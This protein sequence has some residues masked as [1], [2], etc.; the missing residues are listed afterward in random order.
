MPGVL[1]LEEG[2]WLQFDSKGRCNNGSIN[3]LTS[4]EACSDLSQSTSSNTCLVYAKKCTDAE[5]MTA[6]E[7]P[8]IIENKYYFTPESL[9]IATQVELLKEKFSESDMEPGEVIYYRSCSVC[10]A[11]HNPKS[12][13]KEQWRGAFQSMSPRAGLKGEEFIDRQAKG[14]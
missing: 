7:P 11:P 8:E 14:G 6:F 5:K 1:T 9:G 12:L 13:T 10:H 4:S 3:I 2:R